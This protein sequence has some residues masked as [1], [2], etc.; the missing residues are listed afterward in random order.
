[1]TLPSEVTGMNNLQEKVIYDNEDKIFGYNLRFRIDS[2][3]IEVE[4]S[5]DALDSRIKSKFLSAI[6]GNKI[7]DQIHEIIEEFNSSEI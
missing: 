1:M 7:L 6:H 2:S 4:E 5:V 3:Q